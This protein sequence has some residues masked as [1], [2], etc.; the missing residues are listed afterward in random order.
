MIYIPLW[1]YS[2]FYCSCKVFYTY[3]IYIPL[4]S[5]SN[6]TCQCGFLASPVFTFHYGP[7]QIRCNIYLPFPGIHLHS[8]MVLFKLARVT[9]PLNTPTFTFHYGPI[10]ILDLMASVAILSD[11]H[12]TMVLFK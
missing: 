2:N 7:I 9:S 8:T 12:S 11:L 1:S 10:Q 5:Y 3:Y 4:C 6:I